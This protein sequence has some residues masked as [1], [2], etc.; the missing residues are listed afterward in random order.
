MLHHTLVVEQCVSVFDRLCNYPWFKALFVI[1]ATLGS[2]LYDPELSMEMY[3]LLSI[4]IIDM[5][6]ALIACYQKD[7]PVESRKMF[8]TAV[9]IVVYFMLVSA[10]HLVEYVIP[11][12]K[13]DD[14]VIAFLGVTELISVLE[15]F[16]RAGYQVP[17][18]LLSQLKKFKADK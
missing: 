17:K 7:I 3:A 4:I 10:G 9:K 11:V 18:Q 1:L 5:F 16:S 13:I 8:K 15:N 12:P 14:A 6:T 2:F